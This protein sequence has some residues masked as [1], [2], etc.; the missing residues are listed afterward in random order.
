MSIIHYGLLYYYDRTY[1]TA[2]EQ[3]F[4]FTSNHIIPYLQSGHSLF[5]IANVYIYAELP[6]YIYLSG[7]LAIFAN[8]VGAN[9][10]IIQKLIII[11]FAALIP[12]ILYLIL[13]I[14][15][16]E[17]NAFYGAIFYG[18]FSHLTGVSALLLRDVPVALTY[19]IVFWI[20]FQKVSIG[21]VLLLLLTLF[22][23]YYL[24]YETGI[25]LIFT[26]SIYLLASFNQL[27]TNTIVKKMLLFL[28]AA[29]IIV[30]LIQLDPV[31]IYTHF[32]ETNNAE[33]AT[34]AAGSLGA[35]LVF[36]PY[37][38]NFIAL[39]LVSQ[40]QQFPFWIDFYYMG[41]LSLFTMIGYITWF[42]GWGYTL[43][44]IVKLKILQSLDIKIKLLF[45]IA[46]LYILIL[47]STE[48]MVRR[49]MAFYPIIFTIS[50]ISFVNIDREKRIKIFM[51]T[52]FIYV[53]LTI[54]YILLKSNLFSG[55]SF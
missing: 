45:Y 7:H 28:F 29:I 32:Y 15:V 43:Y 41:I 9:S 39:T 53:F 21:N 3:W 6:A 55:Y 25:F 8:M 19:I 17:K 54:I 12:T 24:R 20:T 22:F 42:I 44:G 13:I 31:A 11:F 27:V 16:K 47:A 40:M 1:T 52:L 10:E 4:Y 14:Y 34:K 50:V 30:G 51:F 26:S 48:P 35:S 49:L 18:V 46:L 2:D 37:G 23:S 36:L 5:D 38:L 33:T